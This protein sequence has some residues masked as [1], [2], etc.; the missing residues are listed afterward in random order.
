MPGLGNEGRRRHGLFPSW[1]EITLKVVEN[2]RLCTEGQNRKW[3][4]G[5]V[6]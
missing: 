1:G 3:E 2:K 6:G 4:K 5:E